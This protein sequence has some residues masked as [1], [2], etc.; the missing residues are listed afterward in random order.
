M[1]NIETCACRCEIDTFCPLPPLPRPPPSYPGLPPSFLS[2]SYPSLFALC[3]ILN[4][5]HLV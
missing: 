4:L 3:C 1:I 5:L 2:F